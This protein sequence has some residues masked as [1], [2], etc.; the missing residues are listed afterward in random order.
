MAGTLSGDY[1]NLPMP[2]DTQRPCEGSCQRW[3]KHVDQNFLSRSLFP[4]LFDHSVTAW[5]SRTTNLICQIID[6]P[7]NCD[8]CCYYILLLKPEV[9]K[10]LALLGAKSYKSMFQSKALRFLW[11]QEHLSV[12]R[13][14]SW[15]SAS[16]GS[17]LKVSVCHD[18][19]SYLYG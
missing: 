7:E 8:P 16:G 1:T 14:L 19:D 12:W 4:G 3:A 2:R 5:E 18:Y 9:W 15:M 6:V 17:D 11:L 13:S 10:C